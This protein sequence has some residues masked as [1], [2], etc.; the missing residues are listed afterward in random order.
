VTVNQGEWERWWDLIV[1]RPPG[2]P[3]PPPQGTSLTALYEANTHAILRWVDGH[4][5]EEAALSYRPDWLPRALE[6]TPATGRHV[7]KVLPVEGR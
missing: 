5:P 1:D 3:I 4:T 7:T 6:A 2:R